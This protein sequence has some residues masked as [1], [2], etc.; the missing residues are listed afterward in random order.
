MIVIDASEGIT[1]ED[2]AVIDSVKNSSKIFIL[3]KIDKVDK[4]YAEKIIQESG[5][6]FIE[7]SAKTGSGFKTLEKAI[8]D[9]ISKEFTGF[10]NSFIAD[11]RIISILEK[12]GSG[13]KE[14][15]LLLKR[16]ELPEIVAFELSELMDILSGI[17]GEVTDDDV[18]G[19]IFSRFCIGK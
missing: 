6:D 13:V 3:N 19:S 5:I 8:G 14:I 15:M 12:A 16:G 4:S 17:T 11:A 10:K 9:M 2:R 18:L 7:V 1:E